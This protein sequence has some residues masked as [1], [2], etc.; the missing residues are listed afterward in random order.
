[1]LLMPTLIVVWI[2]YWLWC[3]FMLHQLLQMACGVEFILMIL[4]LC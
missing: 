4:Q 2:T 3:L 1:M